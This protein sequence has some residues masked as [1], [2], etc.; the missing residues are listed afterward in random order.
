MTR[1]F[2]TETTA[3]SH[4]YSYAENNPGEYVFNDCFISWD[5]F[6]KNCT[7]IPD[8]AKA[9]F[10][11]RRIFA[12]KFVKN[13]RVSSEFRILF[14]N[15]YPQSESGFINS[16]AKEINTY[17]NI[18]SVDS[19]IDDCL[20]HEMGLL[21]DLYNSFL[22]ENNL[23][24]EDYLVPDFSKADPK[25]VLYYPSAISDPYVSKALEAGFETVEFNGE[26]PCLN[27]YENTAVE[28][29]NVFSE[30]RSRL[31]Q[32]INAGDIAVTCTK[33]NEVMPY[34]LE[35]AKRKNINVSFVSGR[36]LSD[37]MAGRFFADLKNIVTNNFGYEYVAKFLL[38]PSYP[39]KDRQLIRD[40][41]KSG[42]D[43]KIKDGG[44]KALNWIHKLS[45]AG[46][47]NQCDLMHSLSELSFAVVKAR[48]ITEL[49]QSFRRFQDRFFINAS[50]D[51]TGRENDIKAFQRCMQILDDIEECNYTGSDPYGLFLDVSGCTVYVAP[52][53]ENNIKIYSYPLSCGLDV[54]YHYVI[55]LDDLS[56]IVKRSFS[57][58]HD[59]GT[60]SC[61]ITS[62]VIETYCAT[63]GN[64]FLSYASRTYGGFVNAPA[65]FANRNRIK[66][67]PALKDSY[68]AEEAIWAGE[69]QSD[70]VCTWIQE[71]YF[72]SAIEGVLDNSKIKE[73]VYENNIVPVSASGFDVWKKCPYRWYLQYG[74]GTEDSD[75]SPVME[76]N[77]QTGEILHDTYETFLR[78]RK[79]FGY[80]DSLIDFF[81][82]TLDEHMNEL[83]AT[84][85]IH[86]VRIYEKY[87]SVLK[88]LFTAKGSD[89]FLDSTLV[90][91]EKYFRNEHDSVIEKG[92]IDCVLCLAD[93]SY[94]LI[95]FKKGSADPQSGQLV[96]YGR[97]IENFSG[98]I[99]SCA[100]FYQIEEGKFRN[101]WNDRET[102]KLKIRNIES[103][104]NDMTDKIS[105]KQFDKASSS[106]ICQN[107][108]YRRICRRR[109]VIK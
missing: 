24:E 52:D 84:D 44:K 37:Y 21:A 7:T 6:R 45:G 25:T 17:K 108:P 14:N 98:D 90:Y 87:K 82:K 48:D 75:F 49:K 76:D 4:L 92:F 41:M 40:T 96:F 10:L 66:K 104:I 107:C 72:K 2:P 23:Y 31:E 71:K 42:V 85:K 26:I 9:T 5:T 68:D 106:E 88:N 70:E 57:K 56:C 91:T 3:R 81:R 15:D 13:R 102:G 103:E 12:E 35:E 80:D 54:K 51:S 83:N 30:I 60:G 43:F 101:V 86:G 34:I 18:L 100:S 29:K 93:G 73:E 16:I 79:V 22:L 65:L 27:R 61:D 94:A 89:T 1:V 20:K 33:L 105:R 38:N 46:L 8:T 32:G 53:N 77:R 63:S 109:F 67:C 19:D 74:C 39:F 36:K 62:N 55:G 11:H 95:D 58:S 59:M 97:A 64:V 28:I 50:W 47:E 78:K 99:P 69:H